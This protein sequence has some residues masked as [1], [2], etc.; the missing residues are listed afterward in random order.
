MYKCISGDVNN[1]V[2]GNEGPLMPVLTSARQELLNLGIKSCT[3]GE[4][5]RE[6]KVACSF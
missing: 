3:S 4:A 1:C 2:N 5:F 6:M